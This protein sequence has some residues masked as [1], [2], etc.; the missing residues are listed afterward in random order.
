MND[1]TVAAYTINGNNTVTRVSGPISVNT[2]DDSSDPTGGVFNCWSDV[3]QGA[4]DTRMYVGV[5]GHIPATNGGDPDGPGQIELFSYEHSTQT[6][7]RNGNV[8]TYNQAG[9]VGNHAID[10]AIVSKSSGDFLYA[11]EPR[12]GRVAIYS[13]LADGSLSLL[14]Y[15][16][17]GLSPGPDPFAGSN[18][19]INDFRD[20][21]FLDP[22]PAPECVLGSIQGIAAE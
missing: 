19:G 9:G 16:G 1:S 12:F 8:A 21:C 11:L 3:Q 20:R 4:T 5:F 6:L 2:A 7:T 10:L 22:S 17:D 15:Q 18:P 14:S 13:I